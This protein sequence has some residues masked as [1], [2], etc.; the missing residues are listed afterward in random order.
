MTFY[1]LEGKYHL[2]P[3]LDQLLFCLIVTTS[4]FKATIAQKLLMNIDSYKRK[5]QI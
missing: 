3:S 1:G 5:V 4:T 2:W